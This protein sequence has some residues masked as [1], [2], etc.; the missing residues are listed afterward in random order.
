MQIRSVGLN[1][2]IPT[3]QHRQ[4]QA[5]PHMSDSVCFGGKEMAAKAVVKKTF[6]LPKSINIFKRLNYPIGFNFP[7]KDVEG[8]L[9]HLRQLGKEEGSSFRLVENGKK[10]SRVETYHPSGNIES[11]YLFRKGKL[12]FVNKY[13]D[14]ALK[15]K[16]L[17]E[18]YSIN[19]DG[20][21]DYATLYQDNKAKTVLS[22][23]RFKMTV[24]KN[25]VTAKDYKNISEGNLWYDKKGKWLEQDGPGFVVGSHDKYPEGY[26]QLPSAV[27][28]KSK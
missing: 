8:C 22:F 24:S 10:W 17:I 16:A 13:E 12:S 3:V 5:M 2:V 1:T 15:D 26:V 19:N 25:D 14:S 18:E 21:P 28:L 6:S 4:K 7:F 27:S 20:S 9:A 23:N 11:S